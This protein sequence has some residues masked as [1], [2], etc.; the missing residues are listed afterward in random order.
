MKHL[1]LAIMLLISL[2]CLS[3]MNTTIYFLPGQGSD[4]RIFDS[5]SI[6]PS[7]KIKYIEYG[8]PEKKV[9]LKQFAKQLS[10]RIDTSEKFILVGVSLGGMICAE[11]SE[12]LKPEKVIVISSAKNRSELPFRYKFQRAFPIYNIFPGAVLFAG[13]KILQPIVE[14][15]RNKNKRAFKSMLYAKNSKYIKRTIKMIIKWDRL[16]N[17]NKIIHIHGTSDHTLPI[18]KINSPDHIVSK[19]SHMM[20]LTR[21][22]EIS[23]ILNRILKE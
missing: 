17:S 1:K 15:D 23:E 22:K 20:T 9:S 7:Y 6:D 8:T 4:K 11:M 5:L 18:K 16:S 14:P 10:A 13:A 19:G 2:N 21:A 12:I 3:Q